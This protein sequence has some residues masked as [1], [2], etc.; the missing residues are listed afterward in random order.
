MLIGWF[1]YTAAQASY[2]QATLQQSLAG[3]KVRDVIIRDLVT[4]PSTMSLDE[5]V[6]EYFLKHGFGGFPV[7]ANGR[8]LGFITLKEIKNI[9]REEWGSVTVSEIAVPPGEKGQVF[10]GR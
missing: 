7:M 10:S 2:Q 9:R 8:F 4:L 5:A 6:S 1:L 3:V